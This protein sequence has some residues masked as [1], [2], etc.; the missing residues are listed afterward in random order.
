M[1]YASSVWIDYFC[2]FI[3]GDYAWRIPLSLQCLMG[4][5]LALGAIVI[6]ESPR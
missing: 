1:G 4:G 6:S 3:N 2:S 5:L